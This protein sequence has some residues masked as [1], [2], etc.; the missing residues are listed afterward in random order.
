MS[1]NDFDKIRKLFLDTNDKRL[2]PAE[3]Y[4]KTGDLTLAALNIAEQVVNDLNWIARSLEVIS[5]K[6]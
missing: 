2:T 1:E 4:Q 3:E 6:L 5:I